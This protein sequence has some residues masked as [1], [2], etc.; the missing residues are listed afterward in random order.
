MIYSRNFDKHLHHLEDVFLRLRKAHIRLKPSKCFFAQDNVEY[1]GHIVSR[2]GIRPNPDK[3]S[4]VTEFPVPKNTKGVRSFLGL[5]NCY[6][7]FI[8][9]FSKLAAPLNQLLRKCVCLKWDESCQNTFDA[10][11]HALVTA[12]VLAFPDFSLPFDLYVD[13]SLEGIG[14]TLGQTQ[15]GHEVAIAYAGR[16][17][18]PAERNYSATEHE[19][20][21]LCQCPLNGSCLLKTQQAG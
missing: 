1:L 4:A 21:A 17:L 13:A 6:R 14:M 16:D 11:K 7:W 12:P 3:V 15:K 19:A 20:L 10:L 18:T 2:D 8:Q 9:G 5:A